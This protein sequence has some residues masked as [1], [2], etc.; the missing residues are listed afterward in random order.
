MRPSVLVIAAGCLMGGAF[1]FVRVPARA[2]PSTMENSTEMRA[3]MARAQEQAG[4][5]RKRAQELDAQARAAS[6]GADRAALAAAALAARVQQ[7]EA[8]LEGAEAR[9]ALISAERRVLDQRLAEERA[10]VTRLMAGLQAL[11][12]RPP[13]LSLAQPGSLEDTVHL[14]AVLATVGPQIQAKTRDL[15]EKIT[16]SLALQK[17]AARAAGQRRLQREALLARR[18]S[19]ETVVAEQRMKARRAAGSAD[20]EAERAFAMAEQTRSLGSLMRRIDAANPSSGRMVTSRNP[21]GIFEPPIRGTILPAKSKSQK[22]LEFLAAPGSLVVAP[23]EGRVAFAGAYR[24]Y[25]TVVILE[26]PDGWTSLLTGLAEADVAV[27]QNVVAGSPLGRTGTAPSEVELELRR[28]GA[29]VS[30]SAYMRQ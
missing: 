24:G 8:D 18:R 1:A 12:R 14:R 13:L 28:A 26:H 20:R 17:E 19:L 15:Q 27:G 6:A 25:G 3:E 10:P 9:L 29:P 22:N 30:A 2:V 11:M 21:S 23:R 4:R 7:G 16:R 5:A